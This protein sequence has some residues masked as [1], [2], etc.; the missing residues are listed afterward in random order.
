VYSSHQS[1]IRNG[2]TVKGGL[3]GTSGTT[4]ELAANSKVFGGVESMHDVALRSHAYVDGDVLAA[5]HVSQDDGVV[6]TGSVVELAAVTPVTIPS[7]TFTCNTTGNTAVEKGQTL[8]LTPGNYSNVAVRAGGKLVLQGGSYTFN[9]LRFE[10]GS[11]ALYAAVDIS[12][13]SVDLSLRTCGELYFGNFMH[14]NLLD[15]T[16]A[17]RLKFY[18]NTT[19]MVTIGTDMHFYGS[20]TAPKGE[21]HAYSRSALRG[22]LYGKDVWIEPESQLDGLGCPE[23]PV[24]FT[25]YKPP[26]CPTTTA[27]AWNYRIGGQTGVFDLPSDPNC[28]DD[29]TNPCPHYINNLNNSRWFVSN[30]WVGY[31]GFRVNFFSTEDGADYLRWGLETIPIASISGSVGSG[32]VLWSNT[33]WSFGG[34]R[35]ALNFAADDKNTFEGA[36]LDQVE[37]CTYRTDLD[38]HAPNVLDLKRRYHGVLLGK[39]DVVYLQ[40]PAE[41]TRHYPITL[42]AD[43][44]GAG[45][46]FDLYARCGSL[47]TLTQHDWLGNSSDSQE[48]IDISNCSGTAYVAVH[49][50]AGSGVFSVVRGIHAAG[51]HIA[52]LRAGTEFNATTAQM[53]TFNATL[54]RAARHFYGSTEGEEIIGQIDLYNSQS[55]GPTSC[56]GSK[57]DICFKDLDGTAYAGCDSDVAVHRGYFADGEGVSHE[58]G[59]YKYCIGDEYAN[60]G[61]VWQCGHSN[62]A[63]P[64]GDNN[65]YCVDFDHKRDK[66]PSAPDVGIPSAMSQAYS[67]SKAVDSQNVTFDNFDY[68]NFDF[69][70]LVGLIVQH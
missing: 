1:Q 6:V 21:V 70:S 38:T 51:N 25:P 2:V 17:R 60:P 3:V 59:H 48:Y 67:A 9:S 34:V 44:G 69:N 27:L 61:P 46:N 68:D 40:F 31:I 20:V 52:N 32:T 24:S 62:M 33:S 26:T 29:G 50:L 42:W 39:N 22:F 18:S 56:G 28:S 19:G 8:T 53:A 14:M 41:S 55:C 12:A 7:Q 15:A 58:F 66:T 30:S 36:H 47:P 57:C 35:D 49:S 37:V 4:V 10:S 5:G 16:D 43:M 45:T 63:K 65:N 64:W 23:P 54:Q 13:A 11:S